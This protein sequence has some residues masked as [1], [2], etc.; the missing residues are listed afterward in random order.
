MTTTVWV[1]GGA[2]ETGIEEVQGVQ[3][4]G[5]TAFKVVGAYVRD[6]YLVYGPHWHLTLDLAVIRA[7]LMRVKRIAS[8]E[9]QLAKLKALTFEV[10]G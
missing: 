9:A 7:R 2:L 1:T 10:E 6:D 4:S 3:V 8:L 5:G